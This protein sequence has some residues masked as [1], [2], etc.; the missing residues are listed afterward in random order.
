[1]MSPVKL[2]GVELRSISNPRLFVSVDV[3]QF[4]KTVLPLIVEKKEANST[5][6]TAAQVALQAC[7][8]SLVA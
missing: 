4:N 2:S 6:T 8:I 5:G 3:S 7:H 1:M